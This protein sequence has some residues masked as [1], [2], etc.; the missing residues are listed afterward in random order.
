MKTPS[1]LRLIGTA[2]WPKVFRQWSEQESRQPNWVR[3]ARQQGFRTW[4][5]WR[6]VAI[7]QPLK[8]QGTKW[9]LYSVTD[10]AITIPSWHAGPYRDWR[11]HPGQRVTVTFRTL[12][13]RQAVLR[14][15]KIYPSIKNWPN[16]IRL[17]GLLIK[18]RVYI[19]DGMH[20][21]VALTSLAAKHQPIKPK[22]IIALTERHTLPL[23]PKQT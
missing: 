7:I 14:R 20:R 1:G 18:G 5:A 4:A 17:F 12:I 13:K 21:C 2:T 8:L 6:Q 9:R 23:E 19:I 10:P 16:E 22:I 15:K 3:H 11:V